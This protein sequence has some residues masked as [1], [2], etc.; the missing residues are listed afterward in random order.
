M[1]NPKVSIII[2]SH[3]TIELLT[4]CIGSVLQNT[5]DFELIVVDNSSTDGSLAYL[6]DLASRDTRVQVRTSLEGTTFAE[7]NNLGLAAARGKLICF[8]NSDTIVY[9]GWMKN[10]V[11]NLENIPLNNLG[12]VGP[13][14]NNSNGRQGVGVQNPY[15]WHEQNKGHWKHAGVLYGWCILAKR[16]ALEA[17]AKTDGNFGFDERFRNA[18]ED[19]DLCLRMQM[20]GYSLAIACDTYITHIGQGT[21]RKDPNFNAKTYLENGAKMRE[22]YFDKWYNGKTQRLVAVYRTNGGP[23]FEESLERTSKFADSILIHFCRASKEFWIK[24]SPVFNYGD[25]HTDRNGYVA[26]LQKTF[27]KIKHVEFYDGAFQEDYERNW[28]LQE[29]L[30]MQ[31]KGEADWCI[32][33]DDDELYEEAFIGKVQKMMHPR[34]PE[35]FGYWCQWRTIWDKQNGK[36]YFRTDSTFGQFSNYRFFRLFPGQKISSLHPEG[37]HCGSAPYFAP[38]NLRYSKIRVKHLGYDT[39]EQRQKKFE[40]YQANDH[41]KTKADIGYEDYSHLIELNVKLEEYREKNRVSLVMMVKNEADI[42]VKCLENAEALVDE[43]VIVDTGSTDGTR[44]KVRE[45]AKYSQC[46]VVVKE[47]PWEDNYSTPR[48]YGKY[49]A[50]GDWI[51]MLD[52]DEMFRI[53]DYMVFQQLTETNSDAVIFHVINYLKKTGMNEA[54]VYA[55]TESVRLY[56][57]IPEFY[58]SG[59]IHET[60]DDSLC[61]LQKKR[62]VSV[63]RAPF[64]LHHYGY[65]KS[66][67]RVTE[68]LEYYDVLNRMQIKITDGT[69]PR[70]YFNIALHK[71]NDDDKSEGVTLLHKSVEVNPAFWH[72]YQQLAAVN[73]QSAKEFLTRAIQTM[74]ENHPYRKEAVELLTFLEKKSYGVR[75][76]G[77]KNAGTRG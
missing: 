43:M 25:K 17:A 30:K 76:V 72:G 6:E 38:E 61:A 31:E 23:H 24:S 1:E 54:P 59:M 40:F 3:N 36:E 9:P 13:V 49:L 50:T 48:N 69:D 11:L 64:M 62:K 44:E 73:I 21:M 32:S 51:L 66:D 67:K 22:A 42:I 28:L 45:F 34:N 65:L 74:P 56:R 60:L 71:L 35:V 57:N 8:L 58:Y 55:S 63:L 52:A 5:E 75:K 39:P 46:E 2:A 33:L 19:N 26:Y 18:Y 70:P 37:H 77:A 10:L 27:P 53:E 47:Y 14:T 68:K 4:A 7:A 16:E 15:T 41:F 20:A 29:A 12:A